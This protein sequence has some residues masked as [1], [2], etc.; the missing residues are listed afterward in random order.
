MKLWAV[1]SSSLNYSCTVSSDSSLP[2]L[3]IN[4]SKLATSGL[5]VKNLR[6]FS[7]GLWPPVVT[8][9]FSF[10]N[11]LYTEVG[12]GGGGGGGEVRGIFLK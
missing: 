11:V 4:R 8:N 12:G 6:Q 2:S 1:T 9:L 7:V 3:F 5:L 10:L